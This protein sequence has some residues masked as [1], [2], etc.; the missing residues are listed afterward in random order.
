MRNLLIAMLTIF[1]FA[2]PVFSDDRLEME[3]ILVIGSKAAL[4]SALEKQRN[5]DQVIGVVDSDAL[6]NFADINVAESVRRLPGV[7][8]ENDQGEGRYV[9]LRGMNT[10]LN[11]MTIGG[12]SVMSPEDRRGVILDGVPSDMLDSITVYKT[13]QPFQDLDNIGGSIDLETISAFNFDGIHAK[14]KLDTSYNELTKDGSNPT[15]GLTLTNRFE[16]GEDEL[17]VAFVITDSTRRIIA[18]NN[19][20]GGWGSSYP[21]DDY[22]MRYYDLEREREGIVLNLD[23]RTENGSEY[24]LH[25]FYNDYTDTELRQK[26]ETRDV[27]ENDPTS[28]EGQVFS[29]VDQETE[30]DN[31]GKWRIEART[32]ESYVAG[33]E[34]DFASATLSMQ[35]FYS[36]AEQDDTDRTEANFRTDTVDGTTTTYD[37]IDPKKPAVG[38]DPYFYDPANYL[39]DAVEKEYAL[40]TDEEIGFKLDFEFDLTEYTTVR[41]GLKYRDRE[42][43]NDFVFCAYEAADDY[44]TT[45][46]DY[47]TSS[48]NPYLNTVHAPAPTPNTVRGFEEMMSGTYALQDGRVCPGPGSNL[49]IDDGDIDFESTVGTWNTEEEVSAVYAMATTNLDNLKVIYGLRYEQTDSKFTGSTWNDSS[50]SPEPAQ[51]EQDYGF[52]SPQLNINYLLNDNSNVR[53]AVTRSLVR[54]NFGESRIGADVRINADDNE[55]EIRDAGNPELDP[56]KAWNVDASWSYYFSD[57]DYLNMGVFYKRIED[58]IVQ[59]RRE[60]FAFRGRVWDEA[61]TFINIDENT[62]LKGLEVTYTKTFEN[63]LWFALNYT[64]VDGDMNLPADAENADGE[65]RSV[66]YFKQADS[67]GNAVLGFDNGTWDIRL[68]ANYRSSYLDELGEADLEDRYTD[69]YVSVDLTGKYAINDNLTLKVEALNLSDSPEFYYFGNQRRLSQYDEYGTTYKFGLR[70]SY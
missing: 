26:F 41:A 38:L 27:L 54:P 4:R 3:E 10:D 13:L 5:S 63:G 12:V 58:T 30:M 23:Y 56:F 40:T 14:A 66:P 67:T 39:L 17:G 49:V 48:A 19:E 43:D 51:F 21:N 2:T 6:G 15:L 18:H 53:F 47:E 20:N 61:R 50:G 45:L 24:Y 57:Q 34:L 69:D 1:I 28:V 35:A 7:M 59:V 60:N 70:Y 64:H 9:S 55:Y 32:I 22:E 33:I 44:S 31:E 62:S 36:A 37:N 16:F 25:T 42:K 8:V 29:W 68:A 65:M 11:A 46:A 52:L